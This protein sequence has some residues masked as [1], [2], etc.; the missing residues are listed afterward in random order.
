MDFA[1][2]KLLTIVTLLGFTVMEIVAGRFMHKRTA[3]W[4]DAI[5]DASTSLAL[6]LVAVPAIFTAVMTTARPTRSV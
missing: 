2:A 3:T 4:R 5:I 1:T 6:P